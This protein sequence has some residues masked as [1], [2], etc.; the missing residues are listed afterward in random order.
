MR[1]IKFRAWDKNAKKMYYGKE[2][3]FDDMIGFRFEHWDINTNR[4]DIILMQYT[5]IKDKKGK[6]IYEGDIVKSDYRRGCNVVEWRK[7]EAQFSIGG[8][9]NSWTIIGNIYENL[10]LIRGEKGE[11]KNAE[12]EQSY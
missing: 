8:Y 5:G 3:F 10:E 2:E 11:Q 9:G 4:K 1:E 12:K 6:E 7:K